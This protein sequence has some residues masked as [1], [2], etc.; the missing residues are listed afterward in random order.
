MGVICDCL[1]NSYKIN[2]GELNN[3]KVENDDF[4]FVYSVYSSLFNLN[5]F[6]NFILNYKSKSDIYIG[7]TLKEIFKQNP[8]I[9][10]I[11]RI[12]NSK[13]IIYRI[14]QKKKIFGKTAG[15]IIIQILDLLNEEQI[16][17]KNR[18]H[19]DSFANT[20]YLIAFKEYF[21][22]HKLLYFNN[23]FS[24]LFHGLLKRKITVNNQNIFY[25]YD[26]FSY[27]ELNLVDI[28]NKLSSEGRVFYNSF[29]APVLN[30]ID[31]INEEF[32][33]RNSIFNCLQS[34]EQ[35]SIYSTAPYLI[36]ILNSQKYYQNQIYN[37]F[38]VG[39]F[40]Y[41]QE[42]DIACLAEC[43]ENTNKYKISSIIKEKSIIYNNAYNNDYNCKYINN[44]VD[45]YGQ[46]YYYENNNKISGIFN[47]P[48]YYDHV[49]IYKQ[50]T[51]K[52][53]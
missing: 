53:Q 13:K 24:E 33:S 22:S 23:K 9:E 30:L 11:N 19:S 18:K 27:I 8:E 6:K 46:F 21:E 41:G 2:K 38:N 26:C 51:D 50:L 5:N 43:T 52:P 49:L 10:K 47:K 12:N 14:K 15:S 40:V 16:E 1:K 31:A 39:F 42:I 3:I 17:G 20:N 7:K 45:E 37:F 32:S 34:F 48:G 4:S 36:F 25:S 35:K 28:Y 29:N 44:N